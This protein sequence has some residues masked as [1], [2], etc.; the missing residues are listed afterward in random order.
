LELFGWES[1]V[2]KISLYDFSHWFIGFMFLKAKREYVK[3]RLHETGTAIVEAE[4]PSTRRAEAE[5][6]MSG[7]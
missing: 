3:G 4:Q 6:E 7:G 5:H 2:W 1:I